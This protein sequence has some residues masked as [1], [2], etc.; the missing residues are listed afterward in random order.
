MRMM[1][2]MLVG[3]L[4]GVCASPVMG[5]AATAVDGTTWQITIT[6][7]DAEKKVGEKASKDT[8]SFKGGQL[9]STAC[10]KYGFTHSAFT[11]GGTSTAPS[12][13]ADQTSAK[14]GKM[15]WSGQVAGNAISGTVAWTKKNGQVLHYTFTGK[16]AKSS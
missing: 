12:F 10:V 9:T 7:D 4:V 14:E 11:V 13:Q 2:W 8:L 5:H 15:A 16:K 6:P 3:I 1:R